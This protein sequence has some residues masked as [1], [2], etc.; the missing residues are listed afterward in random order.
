MATVTAALISAG[1]LGPKTMDVQ[2]SSAFHCRL[3]IGCDASGNCNPF[4]VYTDLTPATY[5]LALAQVMRF[6]TR[7]VAP[8]TSAARATNHVAKAH[9]TSASGW[10]QRSIVRNFSHARRC[11]AWADFVRC[12]R[13]KDSL[14][15]KATREK[16]AWDAGF[17]LVRGFGRRVGIV[18]SENTWDGR[19]SPPAIVRASF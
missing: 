18:H 17:E 6:V 1:G 13:P 7:P 8:S 16:E 11:V 14:N 2:R 5:C 19:V 12:A 4:A 3:I 9:T 15:T 10:S